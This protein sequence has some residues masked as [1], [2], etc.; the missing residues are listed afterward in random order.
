M[1]FAEKEIKRFLYYF[2]IN[3]AILPLATVDRKIGG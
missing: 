3:F 1:R 2:D